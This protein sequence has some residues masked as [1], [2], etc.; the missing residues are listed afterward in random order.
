MNIFVPWICVRPEEAPYS[1][2]AALYG[3][4]ELPTYFLINRAGELVKRDEMVEDL[5]KEIRHLLRE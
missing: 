1:K 4:Q 5:E 3:V 2:E